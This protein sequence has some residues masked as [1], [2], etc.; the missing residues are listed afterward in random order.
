MAS[1]LRRVEVG[2]DGGQVIAVRV[3][4]EELESLRSTLGQGGWHRFKTDDAEVDVDLGKLVFV[5]T[6]GDAQKVGF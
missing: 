4:E 6:E 5:R 1:T 3:S 2:F